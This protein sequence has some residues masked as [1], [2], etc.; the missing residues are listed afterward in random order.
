MLNCTENTVK[1]CF[2]SDNNWIRIRILLDPD[3][4]LSK[5]HSRIRIRNKSFWIHKIG[6]WIKLKFL[7]ATINDRI[8]QK[9]KVIHVHWGICSTFL[10][11]PLSLC[12]MRRHLFKVQ[13]LSLRHN[14][15]TAQ[16]CFNTTGISFRR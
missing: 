9:V 2:K 16:N 11:A 1:C 15:S 7:S 12:V 13:R 3:P 5:G 8:V 4:E 6:Y 14:L 10:N